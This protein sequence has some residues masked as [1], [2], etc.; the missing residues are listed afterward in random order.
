MY[1]TLQFHQHTGC[2]NFAVVAKAPAALIG[3]REA[4]AIALV[5]P[6]ADGNELKHF[7]EIFRR[8]K[9]RRTRNGKREA[10]HLNPEEEK[11]GVPN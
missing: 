5:S 9:G 4:A 8:C 1:R 2:L 10:E 11:R 3:A 6:K 7:S